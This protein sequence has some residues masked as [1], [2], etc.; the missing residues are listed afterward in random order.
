M[1]G[2]TGSETDHQLM[3]TRPLGLG[4]PSAPIKPKRQAKTVLNSLG[5][6]FL[7]QVLHETPAGAAWD[8]RHTVAVEDLLKDYIKTL[9]AG[10]TMEPP[11]LFIYQ[12]KAFS[13][14]CPNSGINAPAYCP[15]DHTIYLET[16]LG[17]Q[18]ASNFGDFGALSIL[19]HEYGHAYL[20]KR[21]LHPEGKQGE[22]AADAFAGGFARFVEKRG[23]L[24]P[25]DIDE[26]RATFAAVGDYE[27][28]HH[29]HHGTPAERRQAFEQ[30]YQ[31]GF[32]LPGDTSAPAPT[33][34][35]QSPKAQP[36]AAPPS[37]APATETGPP[38]IAPLN[39]GA[40]PV[41]PLL[42][43]G[44]GGLLMVLIVAGVIN[45]INRAREDG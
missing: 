26:A 14:A 36:P 41:I 25:G 8:L 32:R 21:N 19:A 4:K 5:G 16:G 22:L 7:M 12:G 37:T 13:R 28:Y 3:Q 40:S 30:G 38:P 10:A 33:P 34:P 39:N 35:A 45:M 2:R 11:R 43:L 27:V 17:D 44:I 23:H 1:E 9:P 24:D 42:G 20:A 29:D 15:G 18:V 6:G 31:Q